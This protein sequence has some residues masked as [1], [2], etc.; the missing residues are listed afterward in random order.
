ML[1]KSKMLILP[2]EF[3]LEIGKDFLKGTKSIS[4]IY[5]C[6]HTPTHTHTHTHIYLD[7]FV[8]FTMKNFHRLKDIKVKVKRHSGSGGH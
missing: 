3:K 6:I 8:F 5:V 4:Y 2:I 7:E 1:I